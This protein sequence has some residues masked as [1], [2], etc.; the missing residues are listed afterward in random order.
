MNNAGCLSRHPGYLEMLSTLFPVYSLPLQMDD[1]LL[2]R[3]AL[4]LHGGKSKEKT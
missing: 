1:L 3:H 2:S 4:A